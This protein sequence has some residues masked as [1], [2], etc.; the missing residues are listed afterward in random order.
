M[1][2]AEDLKSRQ[3]VLQG[4]AEKRNTAKIACIHAASEDWRCARQRKGTHPTESP[5]D[6]TTDTRFDAI[7]FRQTEKWFT[8]AVFPSRKILLRLAW[9]ENCSTIR[10]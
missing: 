1:A 5:T 2:D 7:L 3:A 9:Q 8:E 10:A 4:D 6:T